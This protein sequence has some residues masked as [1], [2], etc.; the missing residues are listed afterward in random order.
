MCDLELFIDSP[1]RYQY[2]LIHASVQLA[3]SAINNNNKAFKFQTSWGRL[4]LKPAEAIKVQA[5]E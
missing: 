5:R 1:Y 2:S 4:E 3:R